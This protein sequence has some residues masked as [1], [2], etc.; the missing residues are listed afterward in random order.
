MAAVALALPALAS[1]QIAW[2]GEILFRTLFGIY[3]VD[4]ATDTVRE[5]ARDEPGEDLFAPDWSA[6]GKQIAYTRSDPAVA[7]IIDRHYRIYVMD[8]DGGGRR[9]IT[10]EDI[11]ASGPSWSP[12]GTRIVFTRWLGWSNHL[13]FIDGGNL[14]PVIPGRNDYDPAWSPDGRRIAF[15]SGGRNNDAGTSSRR[16]TSSTTPGATFGV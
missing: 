12:D 11:M 8:A 4:S 14:R 15:I 1:A 13:F 9:A 5:V 7:P 16:S 2:H 3:T 10:P 6:N